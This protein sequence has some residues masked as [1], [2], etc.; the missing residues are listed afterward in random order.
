VQVD[1][2]D[3]DFEL[4]ADLLVKKGGRRF[5]AEVKTGE[6][7]PRIETSATRRQLLE[8]ALAY[9]VDGVLLVEP[10]RGRIREVTFPLEQAH[11]RSGFVPGLLI[12]MVAA[13][14]AVFLW[15]TVV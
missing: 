3:V 2:D 8:Y 6:S 4:R 9:P 12:G 7:A 1:G 14:G 11:T 15:H 5:V 10:Q 13:I